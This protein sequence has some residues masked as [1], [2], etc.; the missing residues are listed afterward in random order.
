M[1][2][3]GLL[4]IGLFL[5]VHFV[6]AAVFARVPDPPV[7]LVRDM[8]C[9]TLDGCLKGD[10]NIVVCAEEHNPDHRREVQVTAQTALLLH[11]GD[12]CPTTP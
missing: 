7:W 2:K 5:V 11:I 8:P 9:A 4:L 3:R 10:N 6:T 12:P 1:I